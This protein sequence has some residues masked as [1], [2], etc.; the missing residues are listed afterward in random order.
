MFF[1]KES[2]PAEYIR[3]FQQESQNL[4]NKIIDNA[5]VLILYTYTDGTIS[6]CNRLVEEIIG[7]SRDSIMGKNWLGV[8][9][10]HDP[11]TAIKQ[12]MFKAVM[13]D[14][15][16]Y[17]RPNNYNGAIK[18]LSNEE[19]LISWNLTPILS[20]SQSVHGILCIGND[21]TDIAEREASVKKIDETVKDIL[22]NIKEYALYAINL[23]GNITY[24]GMGSDVMFGWKK[25]EIILQHVS[26]FHLEEDVK[27][28]LPTILEKVRNTGQYETEIELVGKDRRSFPVILTVHKFFDTQGKLIGFIF[29]AKDV[30]E[31]KK[32]ELQI[33]QSEKM[34]ALGQ[35]SAGMAHEI[36]NPLFVIA[37]RLELLMEDNKLDEGLRKE[38][39]VINTQADRIRK[40]VDMLLKFSRYHP[41]KMDKVD[42]NAVIESVLPFLDY[43]NWSAAKITLKKD[44]AQGLLPTKGDFNQLQ[45]VFINLMMNA[46]QALPN[47]GEISIK[48]RNLDEDFVEARLS[49]TGTGINEES[50]KNIFMPF[51]STKKEGTGLG[52]SICY[53][54]IK[55]HSG[56]ISID[57]KPNVG[58]TFII[59]LP[60]TKEG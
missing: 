52:L 26:I 23:D 20:E 21:M 11:A 57:T 49:D 56:T 31:R 22:S 12:R 30:T 3:L 38:L 33:F 50:L 46:L 13:D 17:K 34:A 25:E 10:R 42:I 32:M 2:L 45:E 7:T 44:F 41:A 8:L 1:K 6:L 40:I 29:I 47:G 19:R 15:I 18:N 43:Q 51:F 4:V 37:G 36:N 53:N 48:T 55:N 24:Y 60:V 35:L 39:G 5:S 58:T 14:C 28:K 16:K 27:T 54:I 9:Y 59:K